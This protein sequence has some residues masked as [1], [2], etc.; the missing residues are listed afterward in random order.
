M[1]S[2]AELRV[3]L[4]MK[5]VSCYTRSRDPA[6]ERTG[7]PPGLLCAGRVCFTP[8][9]AVTSE[10]LLVGTRRLSPSAG[11][12]EVAR[13]P[14][15]V[16]TA[17]R[18][19]CEGRV[20]VPCSWWWRLPLPPGAKPLWVT[21]ST[22]WPHGRVCGWGGGQGWCLQPPEAGVSLWRWLGHR[23]VWGMLYLTLVAFLL[24]RE[25]PCC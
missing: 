17:A 6:R 25:F 7:A 3:A 19:C 15:C 16:G 23:A 10:E 2:R 11:R 4:M 13:G 20:V 9:S 24:N 8:S 1:E 12:L 14:G 22:Q 5:T 18:W 21:E